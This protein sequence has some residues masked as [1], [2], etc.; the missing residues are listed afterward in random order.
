MPTSSIVDLLA[1]YIMSVY[2]LNDFRIRNDDGVCSENPK[3]VEPSMFYRDY[4]DLFVPHQ[5][6]Y[7]TLRRTFE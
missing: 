3:Y 4:F 1:S 5:L 6:C 2:D 7:Y